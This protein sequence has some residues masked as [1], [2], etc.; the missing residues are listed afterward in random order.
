MLSAVVIIAVIR[1]EKL[2]AK[3]IKKEKTQQSSRDIG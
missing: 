2:V 3:I 1:T